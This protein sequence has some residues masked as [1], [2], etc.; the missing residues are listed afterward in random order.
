[1]SELHLFHG[2]SVIIEQSIF[3]R[4]RSYNDYGKGFYCTESLELAKEWACNSDSDG[5]TNEY[6]LE[7]EDLKV[8]NLNSAEY[9]I[10]HWLCLLMQH[11]RVRISSPV[12]QRGKEYLQRNFSID[13]KHYDAIIGYRADDSYFAFARAFLSNEISHDQLSRAMQLGKLGEQFMLKSKRAFDCIRFVGYEIAPRD[14]YYVKRKQR[15]EQ[16]RAGYQADL[17]RGDIEGLFMRDLIREGVASDD[18]RLL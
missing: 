5:F 9:N 1:M 6:L 2:S 7:T 11:R 15:D 16:A 10:L 4:G 13:L 12:A 18:S 14:I 17:E 8:L 3:G